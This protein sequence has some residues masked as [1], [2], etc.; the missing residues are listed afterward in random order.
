MCFVLL[1]KLYV[2]GLEMT[3]TIISFQSCIL[4][5]KLIIF[6]KLNGLPVYV[7]LLQSLGLK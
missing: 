6:Q 5:I 3:Q 1:R 4:I 7:L 2:S